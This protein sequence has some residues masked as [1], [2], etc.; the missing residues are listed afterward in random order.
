MLTAFA[1]PFPYAAAHHPPRDRVHRHG[2]GP[3]APALWAV[4]TGLIC[5]GV[6]L[7][8]AMFSRR[9]RSQQGSGTLAGFTMGVGYLF[10]ALGPLLGGSLKSATGNWTPALFVYAATA[11][12]C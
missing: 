9:T 3:R 5:G 8:I 4:L 1:H 11:A 6:P 2:A 10:G 7:A 12:P